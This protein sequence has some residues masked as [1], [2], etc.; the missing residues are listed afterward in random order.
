MAQGLCLAALLFN[1]AF[2]GRGFGRGLLTLPWAFPDV[3]T[4]LVFVWILGESAVRCD[5]RLR[6]P[7]CPGSSKTRRWLLNFQPG[8]ALDRPDQRLGRRFTVLQPGHPRRAARRPLQRYD[9]AR[10][11][12]ANALQ[13]FRHIIIPGIAPT[14]LLLVVLAAIFSFKQFAIIFLLTGGGQPE[15]PRRR[16]SASRTPRFG[17]TTFRIAPPWVW[18]SSMVTSIVFV[19]MAAQKQ[20]EAEFSY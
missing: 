8:D 7:G 4:V 18:R 3:P 20:D 2:I 12:G 11:D 5:E 14:L 15:R 10:A 19:F 17:S 9:A 6:P 1:R 13:L 16:W